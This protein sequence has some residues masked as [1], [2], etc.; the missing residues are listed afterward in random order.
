MVL[1]V[2]ITFYK[3][4][5]GGF[6]DSKK[7]FVWLLIVGLIELVNISVI[8]GLGGISVTADAVAEIISLDK[9]WY[10]SIFVFRLLYGGL[11]SNFL[12]VTLALS[13]ALPV[14]IA[15]LG[16]PD[17]G[18]VWG[19]YIGAV[20]LGAAFLSIGLF[21]SSLTE[22]QIVAFIISLVL[23]FGLFIVGEEFMVY[24]APRFLVPILK[25]IGMHHDRINLKDQFLVHFIRDHEPSDFFIFF[26]QGIRIDPIFSDQVVQHT[27][28]HF[29]FMDGPPFRHGLDFK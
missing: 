11:M 10:N 12:L 17:P 9:F 23:I 29:L 22:N 21:V 26:L 25:F 20:L 4:Y 28:G 2:M 15:I 3:E 5:G 8:H 1:T 24:R 14:M 13:F 7:I 27:G 19:G 6:D 16:N 18:T